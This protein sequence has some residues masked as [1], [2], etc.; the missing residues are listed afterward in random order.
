MLDKV[1]PRI[2]LISVFIFAITVAI[3]CG[4]LWDNDIYFLI[5]SGR[6]I[7]TNGFST[8]DPLTMHNDLNYITQQWLACVIDASIYDAVGKPGILITYGLLWALAAFLLFKVVYKFS[9]A[10]YTLS[11]CITALF[12]LIFIPFIKCNPRIFDVI[13]LIITIYACYKVHET[14]N[15]KYLLIPIIAQ[16]FLVNLH[17]TMWPVTLFAP[18]AF[19]FAEGNT[20]KQRL[21]YLLCALLCVVS[22][23]INP[24]GLTAITYIFISLTSASL[25]QIG[26][27]ELSNLSFDNGYIFIAAIV[28]P[29]FYAVVRTKFTRH[30]LPLEILS[31]VTL[32]MTFSS[33]RNFVLFLPIMTLCLV[34]PVSQIKFKPLNQRLLNISKGFCAG[35]FIFTLILCCSTITTIGDENITDEDLSRH[36]AVET[37][38][39]NGLKPGDSVFNGFNDGGY[40]EMQGF[41]PYIDERAELFT[42]EI[43]G[44]KDYAREWIAIRNCESPLS[45]VLNLYHFDAIL[46]SKAQSMYDTESQIV[47]SGFV[48]VYKDDFYIGAIKA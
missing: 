14:K 43:N 25:S 4:N 47:H 13:V 16:V 15:N 30:C 1:I 40:L 12:L 11:C 31:A 10:R 36:N 38:K 37:L 7:L 39:E 8:T 5:A 29:I 23:L 24:Y 35:L 46:V 26:I 48:I 45:E 17:S 21:I 34:F 41:K 6:D 20:P 3:I 28:I 27:T 9:D 44:K 42:I 32:M 18:L 33:A 19:I 22:A 2:F